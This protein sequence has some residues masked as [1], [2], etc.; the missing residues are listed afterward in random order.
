MGK[1]DQI[2]LSVLLVEDNQELRDLLQEAI[3]GWGYDSKTAVDGIGAL[4]KLAE[5]HFDIVITDIH[6]PRMDGLELIRH[7][8]SDFPQVEVIAITGYPTKYRFNDVVK[9][10]ASDFIIK[11]F[12]LNELEARLNRII[13]ERTLRAELELLTTQDELT[14]LYNRRYFNENLKREVIRAIRQ[15]YGLYLLLIDVDKFK[16]Y[17]DKFGH[18]IGDNLLEE[19]A[20]II[21]SNI[22][23]DVDSGYRYGGDEFAVIIPHANRQQSLLVANRVLTTYDERSLAPTSLS[24]GMAKLD[25]FQENLEKNLEILIM[26][27]DKDLYLAKKSGGNQVC[28]DGRQVAHAGTFSIEHS[29]QPH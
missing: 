6:M 29:H 2:Q 7:I 4:E 14:G 20:M 18:Q 11:P 28:E 12:S 10:G 13:R 23:Q 15:K 5:N 3:S 25:A 9:V 26:K 19:L 21:L 1:R 27:A 16:V 24:M 22:R 17:N 8:S